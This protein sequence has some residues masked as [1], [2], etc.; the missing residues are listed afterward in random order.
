MDN[1]QLFLDTLVIGPMTRYA[2]DLRPLLKIMSGP[3]SGMLKLDDEVSSK[4]KNIEHF[5]IY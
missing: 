1:E 2:E 3:S 5:N 4:Y